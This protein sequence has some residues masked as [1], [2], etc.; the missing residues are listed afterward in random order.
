MTGTLGDLYV[1]L[2]DEAVGARLGRF[3]TF[4]KR[5]TGVV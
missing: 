5:L 4:E 1:T 3:P 2:A